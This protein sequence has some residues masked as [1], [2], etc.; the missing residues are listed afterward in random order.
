MNSIFEFLL[1]SL[2]AVVWLAALIV[3]TVL[4]APVHLIV[5]IAASVFQ[6]TN[7]QSQ[8]VW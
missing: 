5:M 7:V 6:K 1:R 3:T 8:W 2:I 4:L